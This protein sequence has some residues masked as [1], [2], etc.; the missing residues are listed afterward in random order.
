MATGEKPLGH[1]LDPRSCLYSAH[2][3]ALVDLGVGP[4]TPIG[5]ISKRARGKIEWSDEILGE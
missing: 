4:E 3:A 5:C 1:N 2:S